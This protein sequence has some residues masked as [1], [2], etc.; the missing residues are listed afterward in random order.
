MFQN[1]LENY[2]NVLIYFGIDSNELQWVCRSLH[3]MLDGA[4]HLIEDALTSGMVVEEC[5][6]KESK[7]YGLPPRPQLTLE[8]KL[9][10]HFLAALHLVSPRVFGQQKYAYFFMVASKPFGCTIVFSLFL[11]S[12]RSFWVRVPV[13]PKPPDA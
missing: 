8:R 13:L 9:L 1:I 12:Y 3:A 6:P 2:S 11:F 7:L 5:I 10:R 4:L